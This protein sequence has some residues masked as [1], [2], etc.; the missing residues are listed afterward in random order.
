MSSEIATHIDNRGISQ[1]TSDPSET[2]SGSVLALL[3]D[4]KGA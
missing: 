3:D 2:A 1:R 4:S